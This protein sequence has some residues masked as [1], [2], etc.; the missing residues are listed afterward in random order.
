MRK[1]LLA[2]AVAGLMAAGS[3]AMAATITSTFTANGVTDTFSQQ[4]TAVFSFDMSNLSSFT[5]TLTD[6]VSPTA[7]ILSVLDGLTFGFS[8]APATIELTDITPLGGV[9]DC[10]DS[11]S[12]CPSG[13][14]SSPYGWGTTSSSGAVSLGAGFDSGTSS[15]AYHPFGI[16]NT[17]Y[18][19]PGGSTGLSSAE[20]NPLLVGPVRF[21]FA[22]TGLESVPEIMGVSFAFGTEPINQPGTPATAAV[23]EPGSLALLGVGLLAGWLVRRRAN[24]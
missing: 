24:T 20:N 10:T 23:P 15:F 6:N 11:T 19:A 7:D 4:A 22:T 2:A 18:T 5:V 16:V 12:P 9:I 21:T 13:S 3:G 8:Q 17:S 1:T 14:G